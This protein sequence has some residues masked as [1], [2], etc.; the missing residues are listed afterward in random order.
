[1]RAREAAVAVAIQAERAVGRNLDAVFGVHGVEGAEVQAAFELPVPGQ[2]HAHAARLSGAFAGRSLSLA[3]E[4]DK[5]VVGVA[6]PDAILLFKIDDAAE[7]DAT[8]DLAVVVLN[9]ADRD[10]VRGALEAAVGKKR[11]ISTSGDRAGGRGAGH[12]RANESE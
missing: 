9:N 2:L 7:I 12:K 1:T 6:L 3:A 5:A 11:E 4:R 10:D 8:G